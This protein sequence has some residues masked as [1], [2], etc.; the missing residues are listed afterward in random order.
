VAAT[1][2]PNRIAMEGFVNGQLSRF[3]KTIHGLPSQRDGES[4]S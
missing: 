3:E 1:F 4:A 2:V